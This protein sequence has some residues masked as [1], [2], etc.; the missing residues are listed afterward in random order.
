MERPLHRISPARRGGASFRL[1]LSSPHFLLGLQPVLDLATRAVAPLEIQLV[2]AGANRFFL[3]SLLA[4]G[5]WRSFG[6][7]LHVA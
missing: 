6:T 3:G 5:R 7:H 4:I 2:R 1:L